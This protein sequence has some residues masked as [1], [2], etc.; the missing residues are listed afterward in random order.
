MPPVMGSAA[1]LM[2]EYTGIP[3]RDIAIAALLPA[4]LF[5]LCVYAQVHFR[6]V[7]LRLAGLEPHEIPKLGAAL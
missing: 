6:A 3:Y 2:A 4:L 5:Y 1:F 7:R